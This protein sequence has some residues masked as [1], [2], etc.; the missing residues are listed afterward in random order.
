MKVRVIK[1][2]DLPREE[3]ALWNEFQAGNPELASPY[4]CP[5][6]TLAVAKVRDDV[7]VAILEDKSDVVG[8]F[9]F[10]RRGRGVG[11]PV[12]WPLSD[13]QGVI[14]PPGVSCDAHRLI[15]GCGLSVFDFDHLLVT[16]DGFLPF[17]EATE[18]SPYL[19]LSNGYDHYIE[20]RAQDGT[21]VVNSR[22]A[23]KWRKMEREFGE[24]RFEAR[25]AD[26]EAMKTLLAWKSAQYHRTSAPDLFAYSWPV[27]LLEDLLRCEEP[28]FGGLLSTL[29]AGD[30][31]VAVH[32]GLRSKAVWHYWFPTYGV[33]F[34]KYSPGYY[35]ILQMAQSA[36]ALGLT[37]I[38]LGKGSM[39]YKLRLASGSVTVAS[40]YVA[41]ASIAAAKRRLWRASTAFIEA[42]PYEPLSQWPKK[43]VRRLQALSR[44][45]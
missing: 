18:G 35:L 7:S 29:H 41:R 42:L 11:K 43:A 2:R 8:F 10:Q 40:G 1:A 16:Q 36:N 9:P 32:L 5:H 14:S 3:I 45:P 20:S 4:F 15:D 31:L 28:G 22:M 24:L 34:G 27:Q 38:D 39:D 23:S 6:F 37:T 33:E 13:Y 44:R 12:G 21:K 19:D 17:H 30:Q 26:A 25:S